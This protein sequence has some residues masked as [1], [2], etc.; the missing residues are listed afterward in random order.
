MTHGAHNSWSR[1]AD[2]IGVAGSLLTGLCCLGVPAVLSILSAVGLGF[3]INDAI[4]V[5]ALVV[6]LAVTLYGLWSGFRRHGRRAPLMAGVI[7][8]VG[9]LTSLWFSS[10]VA[11][12]SLAGLV[13]ATFLNVWFARKRDEPAAP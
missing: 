9:L 3:I 13:A 7:S 10:V 2:K 12:V 8:A 1:Y 6:F 11:A 5:P 4:L